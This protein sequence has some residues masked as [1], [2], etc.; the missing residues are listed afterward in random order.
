[1]ATIIRTCLMLGIASGF[2]TLLN[3]ETQLD[4]AAYLERPEL[5]SP[6]LI[7]SNE[8]QFQLYGKSSAFLRDFAV[9]SPSGN[10]LP[11]VFSQQKEFWASEISGLP[12]GR[13]ILTLSAHDFFGQDVS[14]SQAIIR[15]PLLNFPNTV[16]YSFASQPDGQGLWGLNYLIVSRSLAASR[17]GQIVMPVQP[18]KLTFSENY[19]QILIT[20][21]T[22]LMPQIVIPYTS[23]SPGASLRSSARMTLI[24]PWRSSKPPIL[25]RYK[26]SLT[27][28]TGA[29]RS[30]LPSTL[31]HVVINS[32]LDT[33]R[34]TLSCEIMQPGTYSLAEIGKIRFTRRAVT[35]NV[36]SRVKFPVYVSDSYG[37]SVEGAPVTV[38]YLGNV[39]SA[40]TNA[41]GLIDFYFILPSVPTTAIALAACERFLDKAAVNAVT[42]G[43]VIN[44]VE[45]TLSGG[46]GMTINGRSVVMGP[47]LSMSGNGPSGELLIPTSALTVGVSITG[48]VGVVYLALDHLVSGVQRTT[49]IPLAISQTQSS[50]GAVRVVAKAELPQGKSVLTGYYITAEGEIQRFPECVLMG[51]WTRPTIQRIT[52]NN[53]SVKDG[54][55]LDDQMAFQL[56]ASDNVGLAQTALHLDGQLVASRT[57]PRHQSMVTVPVPAMRPGKHT[58]ALSVTDYAGLVST[59]SIEVQSADSLGLVGHV[60]IYPNPVRQARDA[61]IQYEL[62]Q[63]ADLTLT[64][65]DSY[66]RTV[67]EWVFPAG[68]DGGQGGINRV[69]WSDV[70]DFW[71]ARL[72]SGLYLLVLRQGNTVLGKSRFTV[73]ND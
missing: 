17:T 28:Y 64:V 15:E 61:R 9:L 5:N 37:N 24:L 40:T 26:R 51:D 4:I 58:L 47:V 41:Y 34:Q 39:Q 19:S 6:A 25:T 20:R 2:A 68:T 23:D 70:K 49:S 48:N 21:N 53:R 66:G 22:E 12:Y 29:I 33:T 54:V 50:D 59:R 8:A 11:L 35:A 18:L 45:R 10:S 7:R 67:Q 65:K 55:T 63:S 36:G 56:S 31:T 27:T 1:M 14:C 30:F 44:D 38:N 73:V 52:I 16:R 62:T 57:W 3:A 60:L 42:N 69:L 46:A 13:H 32:A 72:G 71:G 43:L